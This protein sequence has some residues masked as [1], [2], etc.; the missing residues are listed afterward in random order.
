MVDTAA[1]LVDEVLP[2]VPLRQWVLSIPV[3]LRFVCV[4]QAQV[5]KGVLQIAYRAIAGFLLREAGLS[6]AQGECA[7]VTLVQPFGGSLN[8]NLHYH[9]LVLEG[10]YT[11]EC[12][13]RF[14]RVEPLRRRNFPGC[15]SG[16]RGE[17]SAISN[18]G[19]YCRRIPRAANSWCR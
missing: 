3:A 12:P 14:I 11:R 6:Q 19:G 5:L 15:W 16:W 13:P 2:G 10:V 9:L 4:R 7:A 8:L 18:A 17:C 1:L